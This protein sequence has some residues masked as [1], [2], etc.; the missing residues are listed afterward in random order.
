MLTYTRLLVGLVPALIFFALG[1]PRPVAAQALTYT[2]QGVT[3]GDGATASGSFQLNPATGLFGPYDITTTGGTS[4]FHIGA[5]YTPAGGGA[6]SDGQAE[7]FT[8]DSNTSG[9][10][11]VNLLTLDLSRSAAAPATY[12]LVP[13]V[14][15]GNT[16]SG[17]GEFAPLNA[18]LPPRPITAGDLVV[19]AAPVP[20]ASW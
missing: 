4:G 20:E 15:S 19:T 12:A 9:G 16:F 18:P 11:P 3:F 13:G 2:L 17:S 7:S 1:V 14:V 10:G 6:G 5:E 8:F